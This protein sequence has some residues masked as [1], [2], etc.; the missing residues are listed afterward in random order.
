MQSLQ[1]TYNWHSP[2]DD[3]SPYYESTRAWDGLQSLACC[4]LKGP[5][6][7]DEF[8][9][10]NVSF[11]VYP[12]SCCPS[13]LLGRTDP[14]TTASN[15]FQPGCMT[16]VHTIESITLVSAL[17]VIC[18][19][20]FLCVVACIVGGINL[21]ERPTNASGTNIH[22]I[23]GHLPYQ[24]VQRTDVMVYP[25]QPPVNPNSHDA[26]KITEPPMYPNAHGVEKTGY[27][28][29]PPSYGTNP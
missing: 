21:D 13:Y 27:T 17:L 9:P 18:F 19:N 4:G 24:Q 23:S 6:D 20:I 25:R 26:T 11:N 7:W 22:G 5:K 3:S 2:A 12:R 29:P 14:C 15:L 1:P 10:S 28:Q 16:V 8:R